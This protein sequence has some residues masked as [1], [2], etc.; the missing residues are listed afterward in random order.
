MNDVGSRPETTSLPCKAGCR[1]AVPRELESERV[2]VTHFILAIESG[3]HEM[4]RETAT[5]FATPTR[6]CEIESYVKN[7][8][9]KLSDVATSSTRLSD[10]LK[11]RVL[12]TLL[13]LMNLQES[14]DRSVS[15]SV[16]PR[17]PQRVLDSARMA[18]ALRG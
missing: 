12:T 15:R 18:V 10:E 3:C 14:L 6:R 7:T 4:R 5:G 13:T 9:L 2:C 8:A 11:K 1:A 17:P 16:G